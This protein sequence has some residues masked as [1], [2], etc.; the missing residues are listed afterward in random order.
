MTDSP[1]YTRGAP[2]DDR[3]SHHISTELPLYQTVRMYSTHGKPGQETV[4]CGGVSEAVDV[5]GAIPM[6]P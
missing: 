5:L 4:G 1:A 3:R 6:K 2:R